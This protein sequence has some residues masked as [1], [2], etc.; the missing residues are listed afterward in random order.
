[1]TAT[2]LPLVKV[3]QWDKHVDPTSLSMPSRS[4]PHVRYILLREGDVWAHDKTKCEAGIFGRGCYHEEAANRWWA[5][6]LREK[7]R[8]MTIENETLPAITEDGRAAGMALRLA[9]I[10]QRLATVREFFRDVMVEGQ[11]YGV[12]PGT[13]K[14]TLL[15]AGAESL[16]ELYGYAIT[17]KEPRET[18]DR[19]TGFYRVVVTVALI[20][21]N[22]GE[23][24]AEGVGEANTNE[25]RYR[26]RWVTEAK[27]PK[28]I[29]KGALRYE[30]RPSKFGA[31]TYRAY[32]VENDD[33]WTLWNTVLK[34][35]KKRALV[36]ATLSATR[37]SGIFTQDVEDLRGWIETDTDMAVAPRPRGGKTRNTPADGRTSQPARNYKQEILDLLKRMRD[38]WDAESF[39]AERAKFHGLFPDAFTKAFVESG[40]AP[41][42]SALTDEQAVGVALYLR[43]ALDGAPPA[44]GGQQQPL[45]PDDQPF[46]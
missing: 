10:K 29:D 34:M 44:A 32:L 15:K 40:T 42:L 22:T 14:P 2:V 24:V 11:D 43:E 7:G 8:L 38:E 25:G 33:P 23:T 19:A 31:G 4:K 21:R 30:D 3:E 28:G 1:M 9:D 37:S 13:E 46:E 5:D 36:D 27:L 41:K 45:D 17:V 18:I 35:A 39:R 26:G 20:R 12:I 16:C 6:Y